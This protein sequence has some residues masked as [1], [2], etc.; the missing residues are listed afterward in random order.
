VHVPATWQVKIDTLAKTYPKRFFDK[1]HVHLP[2]DDPWGEARHI[3]PNLVAP[4]LSRYRKHANDPRV[5]NA[6]F[7]WPKIIRKHKAAN[8]KKR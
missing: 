2:G 7:V 6:L 1:F 8:A 5:L 4:C 3:C